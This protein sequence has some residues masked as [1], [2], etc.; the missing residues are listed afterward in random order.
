MAVPDRNQILVHRIFRAHQRVKCAT[1]Q[2]FRSGRGS[3]ALR[4]CI[5]YSCVYIA[6]MSPTLSG[7]SALQHIKLGDALEIRNGI[8][9]DFYPGLPHIILHIFDF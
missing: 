5:R 7:S 8:I 1:A 6:R 3:Y 4:G 9:F 2:S